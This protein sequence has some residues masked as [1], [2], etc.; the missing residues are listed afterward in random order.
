[1]PSFPGTAV[2]DICY[3]KVRKNSL[4]AFLFSVKNAH[5]GLAAYKMKHPVHYLVAAEVMAQAG[6][7]MPLNIGQLMDNFLGFALGHHNVFCIGY[8]QCRGAFQLLK[9]VGQREV[10]KRFTRILRNP[11]AC[12]GQH[13]FR[14][15]QAPRKFAH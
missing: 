7:K 14:N 11:L 6:G 2:K 3:R 15:A 1:M 5:F 8:Q 4:T 12:I 9:V 13:L 10:F